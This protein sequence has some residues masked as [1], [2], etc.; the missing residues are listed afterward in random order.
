MVVRTPQRSIVLLTV[1]NRSAETLEALVEKYVERGSVL[2]TDAW[3]GYSNLVNLGFRH[4]VVNHSISF[5]GGET[6]VHTNTIKGCWC[7]VKKTISARNRTKTKVGAFI[8][9]FMLKRNRGSE[10]LAFL[11]RILFD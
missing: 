3:R 8:D 1:E 11:V 10:A 4:F 7:A 5:V 9:L 6:G 2:Y